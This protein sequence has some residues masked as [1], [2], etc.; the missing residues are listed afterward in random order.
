MLNKTKKTTLFL[1]SY[2]KISSFQW[3]V[4]IK[5][6]VQSS[7]MVLLNILLTLR[8]SIMFF[9]YISASNDYFPCRQHTLFFPI[10]VSDFQIELIQRLQGKICSAEYLMIVHSVLLCVSE[11]EN[12]FC[13]YFCPLFL[14]LLA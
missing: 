3:S 2:L 6:Y 14:L 8:Y 1:Y 5:Q 12:V 10:F 4:V 9:S 7:Q 11:T 13:H